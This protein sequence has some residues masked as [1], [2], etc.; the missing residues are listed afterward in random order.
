MLSGTWSVGSAAGQPPNP[1]LFGT[2]SAGPDAVCADENCNCEILVNDSTTAA[3]E[4]RVLADHNLSLQ[5]SH[6]GSSPKAGFVMTDGEVDIFLQRVNDHAMARRDEALLDFLQCMYATWKKVWEEDAYLPCK[7]SGG[8][9]DDIEQREG[10]RTFFNEASPLLKQMLHRVPE[11]D[12]NGSRARD[13]FLLS[14]RKATF[15]ANAEVF[16]KGDRGHEFYIVVDGEATVWS[17][18]DNYLVLGDRVKNIKVVHFGGQAIP[19]GTK[20]VIDKY[21]PAREYPYTI[22]L[23]Q[24]QVRG[25]ILASEVWPLSGG[26]KWEYIASL[27]RGDYFGEVALIKGVHRSATIRAGPAGPLTVYAISRERFVG[28]HDSFPQ[29]LA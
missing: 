5:T 6:Q 24:S 16:C 19:I 12:E 20:G 25:R 3:E 11:V 1:Q 14:V 17:H 13:K 10:V 22:R 2:E 26:P 29:M 18:V 9:P 7:R 23:Q 21:D 28:T 27:R 4:E 15:P 8:F